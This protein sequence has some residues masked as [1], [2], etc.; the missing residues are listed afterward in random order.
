MAKII[1]L[2]SVF[3]LEKSLFGAGG[4][5]PTGHVS[6]LLWPGINFLFF[7]IVLVLLFRENIMNV[8]TSYSK[9]VKELYGFATKRDEEAQSNLEMYQKRIHTFGQE[10]E[11]VWEELQRDKEALKENVDRETEKAIVMIR[12]EGEK[13]LQNE[14]E[15]FVLNFHKMFIEN[16][17]NQAR[18]TIGRNKKIRTKITNSLVDVM[19]K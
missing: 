2:G 13:R 14:Q 17:V 15:T 6:D 19:N 1:V 3:F 16:I 9:E 4:E 7:L 10:E 5:T 11:K 12:K 8:F 18:E